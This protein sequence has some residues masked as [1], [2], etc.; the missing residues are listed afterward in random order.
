M[1]E[2]EAMLYIRD[3]LKTATPEMLQRII[4]GINGPLCST[5]CPLRDKSSPSC[6]CKKIV[7]K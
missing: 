7:E 6:E 2:H 4:C 1:N 5:D 3:K